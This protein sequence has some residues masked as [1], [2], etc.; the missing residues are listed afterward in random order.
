MSDEI[1]LCKDCKHSRISPISVI[2]SYLFEFKQPSSVFYKCAKTFR[3]AGIE[4]DRVIG[5]VKTASS[6]MFCSNERT[7]GD[8][9]KQAKYW[10]P[11]H[12]KDL[13]KLLTRE[14]NV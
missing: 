6:M 2:C 5:P 4:L 12:K 13:F 8:C 7:V 11:K 9:G 10:Q 3:P 14:E 1:L